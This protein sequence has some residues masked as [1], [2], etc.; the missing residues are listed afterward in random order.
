MK[1]RDFLKRV[2][3][4]SLLPFA[5]NGQPI[6]AYGKL[7]GAE[8]ED[9]VETDNVLVL[10]QLNGG[11]DGLNTLIPLDQYANLSTARPDVLIPEN[12]VLPLDGTSVT[13]LHP[14][15]DK[16]QAMYNDGKMHILQNVGYPNQNY[17]HFR[18][19]DIWLTGSDSDEVLESG[20]LG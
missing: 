2:A 17:S 18:S 16:M 12:K 8:A 15:M 4:M 7:M 11:N 1:R 20:W 5:I 3:P 13:G 19:T 10:V 14:A 9:F 6:R